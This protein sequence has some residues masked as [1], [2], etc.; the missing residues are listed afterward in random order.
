MKE[1]CDGP[2]QESENPPSMAP[3]IVQTTAA[4]AI[5]VAWRSP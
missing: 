5:R 3:R 1:M 4:L 2:H